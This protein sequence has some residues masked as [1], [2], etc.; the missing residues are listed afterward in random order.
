MLKLIKS[1]EFNKSKSYYECDCGEILIISDND[2]S[3]KYI[4]S[5]GCKFIPSL[6]AQ[7]S[8]NNYNFNL[9]LPLCIAGVTTNKI[10]HSIWK[11]QCYCGNIFT[12][13]GFNIKKGDTT[14]CGCWHNKIHSTQGGLQPK[15]PKEYSS[16][17]AMIARCT[18]P[19]HISWY[20][21]GG[22]GIFV[23]DKWL[24]HNNGFINFMN[25]MGAMPNDGIIYS[26]N[27]KNNLDGYYK[28]NCEWLPLCEQSWYKSDVKLCYNK[29]NE[30]RKLYLSNQYKMEELS[31]LY[32]IC[33]S[34]ISD[35]INNKIWVKK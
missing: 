21:Y 35:I 14:S 31:Q 10:K 25:D 7:S 2:V 6:D 16:Y 34:N 9:L 1:F 20:Y 4:L 30:I 27:R 15:Y 13:R 33:V 22:N 12:A 26:I 3:K 32:N 5:C 24:R 23:S 18:D 17:N 19:N 8:F 29:A 11:I 28:N